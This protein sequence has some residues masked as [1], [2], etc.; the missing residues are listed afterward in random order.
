MHGTSAD[1]QI[2][3]W[4]IWGLTVGAMIGSGVFLLPTVL[5]PFGI[6][7]LCGWIVTGAGAICIALV[8]GRLAVRSPRSG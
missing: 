3:F 7:A 2:G 5:A 4:G 1:H 6:F 8:L